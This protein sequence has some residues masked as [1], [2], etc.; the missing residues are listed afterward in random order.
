MSDDDR[1]RMSTLWWSTNVPTIMQVLFTAILKHHVALVEDDHFLDEIVETTSV[2]REDVDTLQENVATAADTNTVEWGKH[3]LVNGGVTHVL[4]EQVWL[5]A[6]S[7][8]CI[9]V[10]EYVVGGVCVDKKYIPPRRSASRRLTTH[11]ET[12][13]QK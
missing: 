11:S 9:I 10:H 6:R 7:Q 8:C 13:H 5:F 1:V 12:S 2:L 3:L 4:G